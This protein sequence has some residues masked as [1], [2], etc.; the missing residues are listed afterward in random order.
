MKSILSALYHGEISPEEQ[1]SPRIEEYRKLQQKHYQ[2]YEDFIETLHNEH[3]PLEKQFIK[4]MDEQLEQMPYEWSEM[5]RDGFCLGARMMMEIFQTD[6]H[7]LGK[8][9]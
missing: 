1:Y 6:V 5:L 8:E 9:N 7:I 4:I 3:P 2:H